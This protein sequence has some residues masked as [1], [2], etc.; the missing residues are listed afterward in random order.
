MINYEKW[1]RNAIESGGDRSV[2][3]IPTRYFFTME[4][5]GWNVSC[6][7]RNITGYG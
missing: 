6:K 1:L 4:T 3:S 2:N 5:G 7:R